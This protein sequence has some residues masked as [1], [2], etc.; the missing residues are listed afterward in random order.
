MWLELMKQVPLCCFRGTHS[1]LWLR[2]FSTNFSTS[3][4]LPDIWWTLV[5]ASI[6]SS[7]SCSL[8][9][10]SNYERPT[11]KEMYFPNKEKPA[12]HSTATSS[13]REWVFNSVYYDISQFSVNWQ[14]LIFP[15]LQHASS[16]VNINGGHIPFPHQQFDYGKS[17]EGPN[18]EVYSQMQWMRWSKNI[19]TARTFIQNSIILE[20]QGAQWFAA[21]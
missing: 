2:L 9:V 18:R 4:C 16:T 12:E 7:L 15:H 5:S 19:L 11:L 21:Q 13:W 3:C 6:D 1:T 20:Q 8:S 17:I 10:G 14:M